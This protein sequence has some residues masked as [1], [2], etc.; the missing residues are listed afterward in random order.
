MPESIASVRSLMAGLIDYAGLFPPAALNMQQAVENYA[1]YCKSDE[2]WCLGR[3]VVPVDFLPQFN[4]ARAGYPETTWRLSALAGSDIDRDVHTI[5][6]YN[7]QFVNALPTVGIQSIEVKLS[8]PGDVRRIASVVPRHIDT[9]CEVSAFDDP[10]DSVKRVA[11]A[12]LRAKIRTGG[13][14]NDVFPSSRSLARFLETCWRERVPFKATAGLHHSIR[15]VYKLTYK[16]DSPEGMMFGFLNVFVASAFLVKGM[17]LSGVVEV[18]EEQ[19]AAAFQFSEEGVSW[20]SQRLSV[21]D[22]DEARST[23]SIGF[24]SC[25]FLEPLHDLRTLNLI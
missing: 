16:P 21:R 11:D 8:D 23:F 1:R 22:I 18:L 19:S 14:T 12:G 5:Q 24:G 3:F 17:D 20:R 9:Y 25:S 7:G 15:S 13:I 4:S 10:A 6:E 2:Q